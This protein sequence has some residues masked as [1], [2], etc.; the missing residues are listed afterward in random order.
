LKKPAYKLWLRF[1]V[2]AVL[3]S[4]VNSYGQHS[5][6]IAARYDDTGKTIEVTQ[7]LIYFNQSNDTISD[8][9]LN[10]WNNAYSSKK[11]P[12]AKRF[13]DEF[14]RSFHLA[15]DHERGHTL[16]SSISDKDNV[17]VFWNRVTDHPDL[18]HLVLH[19][20][21]SPGEK[22]PIRLI[23][24][25]KLP[26]NKF[27]GYG[28]GKNG[29]MLRNNFL[30]PARYINEKGFAFYSN[31]DLDDA[32]NAPADYNITFSV[33]VGERL[34]TDLDSQSPDAGIY[35]LSGT[36]RSLFTIT[37]TTEH[38]FHLFRNKSTE[39][40]SDLRENRLS[41]IQKALIADRIVNFAHQEIGK[42]AH[43]KVM[44]LQA[45]Y[46]KNPFY[47][48]NQLPSFMSPFQNDFL[49][50]IKFL[51]TYLNSFLQTSLNL[52]SRKDHH[53]YDGIKI[54]YMMKYIDVYYPDMKMMGS[55]SRY[56]LIRNYNLTTLPFNEQYNYFYLL[57]ARKNLDQPVGMPRDQLIKFNA[58]IAVKYRAGLNMKYLAAFIGKDSLEN[59]LKSFYTKAASGTADKEDFKDALTSSTTK[60]ID[61]F[62][63][64]ATDTRD[65]I[66]YTFT[67]VQ[68]TSDSITVTVRNRSEA[69]VPIPVYAVKGREAVFSTWLENV[70][71]DTTFTMPRRGADRVIINYHNE[72]PEYNRRNNTR[73]L[74]DFVISHRPFKFV[75]MKDLED[76][77]Y[78]QVLYV[79]TILYNLY[80]GVS[81]GMRVHNKAILDKPFVFDI[82]PVYSSNTR[83]LIGNFTLGV[84]QFNRDSNLYHIRYNVSGSYF[85]YAP[86]AAYFK[87]NPSVTF[88]MRQDDL[89]DNH[90]QLLLLRHV[91][92]NQEYYPLT[93]VEEITKYN[94]FNARFINTDSEATRHF[95]FVADFQLSD[96]FGKTSVEMEFRK[97]YNDNRQ[98]SLRLFAGTFL[99]SNTD[100]DYFSF[101]LDRPT[102]YLFDYNYYGRSETTGIF[103]QQ[104]ILAEGA[105][106]SRFENSL[107]NQWITT[108]NLGFNIWNWVEVYG[109]LGFIKS[110][111][112]PARF[113]YDSGIRL[114]LVTDYFELYFPVYSNN[115]WEIAQQN[116][117]EKIR[118]V[119]TID[120][121][122]LVNLF[123]RKWF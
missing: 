40:V 28:Y 97:L 63:K 19:A 41:D 7:E 5:I 20:P 101:G 92:V 123:T 17:P 65:I 8:I 98:I 80:D 6:N 119:V 113:V 23:Y 93:P 72:V 49:Y 102:D 24:Q 109:D 39:V 15:K 85:H 73:S 99:Y 48:L 91:F 61:W 38:N 94:V 115:G 58:Q 121:R 120:P 10:D 3:L 90:K 103:S 25:L 29:T 44:V 4:G 108:A 27:T 57:M 100:T 82:N 122:I 51:K 31:A 79:P 37:T 1:A 54:Y 62:F 21:L 43:S 116:Y 110:S 34:F 107:A 12:L 117:E 75:I 13:S 11:T 114:N 18:I 69:N 95:N 14:I 86:D 26:D 52:D 30:T 46:D 16:I 118:F 50:E 33:P 106:K 67:E 60:N 78:S 9:I 89:R 53:I 88:R 87:F 42:P 81:L 71:K 77:N 96:H 47:G 32:A 74:K 76:P 59:A 2:T 83:S 35:K 45:D 68:K 105:F 84:N 64:T 111:N 104:L 66:D 36:N 56:W 22:I 112:I 70:D 55:V